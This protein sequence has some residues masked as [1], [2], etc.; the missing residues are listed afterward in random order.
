MRLLLNWVLSALAVWIVAQLGIGV[1]VR[2][3]VA[4]LVAALVIG[5]INCD[6]WGAAEDTDFSAHAAYAWT[7]LAS[8]QRADAG[9]GVR[10]VVAGISSAR[11][12]SGVCGGNCVEPGEPDSEGDCHAIEGQ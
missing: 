2:G 11:I 5:F 6:D 9:V 3:A 12:S 7:F 10:P 8:D 4:A 1:S